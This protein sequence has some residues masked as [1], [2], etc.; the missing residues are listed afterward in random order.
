MGKPSSHG[1]VQLGDRSQH[2]GPIDE[3]TSEHWISVQHEPREY[4]I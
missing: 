2:G 3:F 1:A 4:P